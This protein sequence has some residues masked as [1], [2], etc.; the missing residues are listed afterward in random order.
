[1]KMEKKLV[2]YIIRGRD[3]MIANVIVMTNGGHNSE[4]Y[5]PMKKSGA[6]PDLDQCHGRQS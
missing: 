1:M 4:R 2:K 5:P 3:M 6:G